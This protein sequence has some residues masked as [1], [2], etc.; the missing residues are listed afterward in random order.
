M[1]KIFIIALALGSNLFGVSGQTKI[2]SELIELINSNQWFKVYDYSLNNKDSISEIFDLCAKSYCDTYFNRPESA[3]LNI[4]T[5]LNKYSN[6]LGGNNVFNY[7]VLLV[8]NLAEAGKYNE[9]IA[10]LKDIIKQAGNS[11]PK[12]IITS[13]NVMISLYEFNNNHFPAK[14]YTDNII[15]EYRFAMEHAGISFEVMVNNRKMKAL[16]DTGCSSNVISKDLADK[17]GISK[18]MTDTI[19]TNSSIK[20]LKGMIDSVE[21]NNI[22]IYNYPVDVLLEKPNLSISKELEQGLFNYIDSV[23]NY[24]L[25]IGIPTLKLLGSVNIDFI[26]KKIVF[27]QVEPVRQ[28]PSNLLLIDNLLYL[29]VKL[30][31]QPFTA[32][33]DTGYSVGTFLNREYY[34]KH[35]QY[36]KLKEEKQYQINTYMAHGLDTLDY[37]M[38]DDIILSIPKKDLRIKNIMVSVNKPISYQGYPTPDGII[39][40]NFFNSLKRMRLDFDNMYMYFE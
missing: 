19:L 25:L 39:G 12:E 3:M 34:D 33:Y 5:L 38:L 24:D 7:T 6:E 2:D 29:N 8:N 30:N 40:T 17:I 35:K 27:G 37:K 20:T 15:P 14:H 31:K 28:Q 9:A 21:I 23:N 10:I 16:L 32:I 1:K 18:Y 36:F 26:E 13:F 22:K 4:G 11:L